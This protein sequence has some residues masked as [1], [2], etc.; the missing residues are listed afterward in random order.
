MQRHLNIFILI[1]IIASTIII[2]VQ[3]NAQ[4]QPDLDVHFIDVGQG[5]SMLIQTP[6]GK[7]VL[8]DGGRPKAGKK[9]VKFLKKQNVGKI[10]LMIATHP[11]ID[12]I[13]GL[14]QVMKAF[15]VKR[16]L[17]TGKMNSTR[18]YARYVSQIIKQQIPIDIA[19]QNDLI[20]L[21][22]KLKVRILNTNKGSKSTNKSS[23][24]M[25]VT[26]KELDFLLMSDVA[27][28]QEKKLLKKYELDAEI[29]KVA[30]HGSHTSTS[31]E[32][33]QEVDPK[34][35]ILT[36]GKNNDFGHPV[37]RVMENL[38]KVDTAIYPT[39]TF[40]NITVR[41]NGKGYV[42]LNEK[43]PTSSLKAG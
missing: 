41:T 21:D 25:K 8:V 35:A 39:A 3:I 31:L 28:E 17:D 6:S 11:D 29:L 1:M 36:Y 7:N 24:V 9:V 16:I 10:D 18:T 32:F 5:D 38:R 23:I 34:A 15:E 13:G 27:K 33:L 43:S 14:I 20:K 12:H 2:P 40:G 22:P 42:I 30:H 26:F 4:Q 37:D 19:R